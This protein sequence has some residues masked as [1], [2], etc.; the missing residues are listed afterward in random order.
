M[1]TRT[2]HRRKGHG[3]YKR[4]NTGPA[5]V[6]STHTSEHVGWE[7]R[8]VTKGTEVENRQRPR[9]WRWGHLSSEPSL[10][11]NSVEVRIPR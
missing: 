5:R 4:H 1:Q 6:Y 10:S 3:G 2:R 7:S 11:V 9:A 8:V